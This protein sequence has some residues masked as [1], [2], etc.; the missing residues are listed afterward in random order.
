MKA[1]FHFDKAEYKVKRSF[2]L[3]LGI[4]RHSNKGKRVYKL[5]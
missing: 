1:K 3:L 4:T 5:S 2:P